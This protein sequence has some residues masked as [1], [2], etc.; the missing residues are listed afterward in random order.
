MR[1]SRNLNESV[2][3]Q[4]T[5]AQCSKY[6]EQM[7][8]KTVSANSANKTQC[9]TYESAKEESTDSDGAQQCD[10]RRRRRW[11]R[12]SRCP[13]YRRA[14]LANLIEQ[15]EQGSNVVGPIH[16]PD[17]EQ[18]TA[19]QER[20]NK[21]PGNT[22]ASTSVYG[23]TNEVHEF[24]ANIGMRASSSDAIEQVIGG[25][26]CSEGNNKSAA[27][28]RRDCGTPEV[29]QAYHNNELTQACDSGELDKSVVDERLKRVRRRGVQVLPS[30][31]QEQ[32]PMQCSNG[33][34]CYSSTSCNNNHDDDEVGRRKCYCEHCAC[35][36]RRRR[37]QLRPARE[38]G[39]TSRQARNTTSTT[40]GADLGPQLVRHSSSSSRHKLRQLARLRRK[41]NLEYRVRRPKEIEK[42]ER[43]INELEQVSDTWNEDERLLD[44]AA[45]RDWPL[46][47]RAR[48]SSELHR[49]DEEN[50]DIGSLVTTATT[51]TDFGLRNR[52][53]PIE[54]ESIE[55]AHAN[56]RYPNR[57]RRQLDSI[58]LNGSVGSGARLSRRS[59]FADKYSDDLAVRRLR[60]TSSSPSPSQFGLPR[61]PLGRCNLSYLLCTPAYTPSPINTIDGSIEIERERLL[62]N[63]IPIDS[64]D[65]LWR[66]VRT[67]TNDKAHEEEDLPFGIPKR[68]Q[69]QYRSSTASLPNDE[70]QTKVDTKIDTNNQRSESRVSFAAEDELK[71]ATPVESSSYTSNELMKTSLHR[72]ISADSG[73]VAPGAGTATATTT[74]PGDDGDFSQNNHRNESDVSVTDYF[75]EQTVR[76]QIRQLVIGPEETQTPKISRTNSFEYFRPSFRC[77]SPTFERLRAQLSRTPSRQRPHIPI[78]NPR[79]K[80]PL[81][82]APAPPIKERPEDQTATKSIDDSSNRSS[83]DPRDE[84]EIVI[85]QSYTDSMKRRR[86]KEKRKSLKDHKQDGNIEPLTTV[87]TFS[88][89]RTTKTLKTIQK[90]RLCGS[91]DELECEYEFSDDTTESDNSNIAADKVDRSNQEAANVRYH[92][93]TLTDEL[94]SGNTTTTVD[95][96]DLRRNGVV[97]QVPNKAEKDSRTGENSTKQ[98]RNLLGLARSQNSDREDYVVPTMKKISGA[99]TTNIHSKPFFSIGEYRP[100]NKPNLKIL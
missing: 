52:V 70:V 30:A 76:E 80:S 21:L 40:L 92:P 94:D 87:T 5:T 33:N 23:R 45:R 93:I 26:N 11:W 12:C 55:R 61:D 22:F 54:M 3:S 50:S 49:S 73:V 77:E 43:L 74:P 63:P 78:E 48:L 69:Q 37:L 47:E 57:S 19:T 18:Q 46:L 98:M 85:V 35:E 64:D 58:S 91:K 100:L 9:N 59:L 62:A 28:Q 25:D 29:E 83:T 99:T 4:Q 79:S 95:S 6:Q 66:R 31:N 84:E 36:R 81:L 44:R 10:R 34:R 41:Q 42:V 15:F 82:R 51:T 7:Q 14:T 24:N 39:S 32:H 13:S 2:T 71:S 90:E 88:S 53:H 67:P 89:T 72:C 1:V 38:V 97:L 96:E 75:N 65:L 86:K 27:D 56:L 68:S 17:H 8:T 20:S 60:Q 16:C